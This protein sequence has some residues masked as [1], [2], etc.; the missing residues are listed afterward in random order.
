MLKK[1]DRLPDKMKKEEVRPYYDVLIQKRGALLAKRIFDVF[2]S[3][4]MI[5]ILSPFILA[6]A[7]II[8]LS[9]KGSVFYRQERVTKYG[10][11]FKIFKFRTM[12]VDA[13]KIGAQVT[14]QDD[15]RITN[16]GVF[17]RK[18]RLD[19]LPQLFNV[20]LGQM[21]FVGTRPEVPKYVS[22]YTDEMMATLLMPAGVT[23]RASIEYK[24]EAELIGNSEDPDKV[25][26]EKVLPGKMKYNLQ[27][28]KDFSLNEEFDLLFKTISSVFGG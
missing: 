28:I 21:S 18:Y 2:V 11:L 15:P 24:D 3:A 27:A 7:I 20:F 17:L 26:I 12:V 19:E 10:K 9:D 8:K 5:I 14:S 16:I 1:W 25:Y 22:E 13:D 6:I 23:S 4:V